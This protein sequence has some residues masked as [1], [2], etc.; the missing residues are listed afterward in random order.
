[1][2]QPRGKKKKKKKREGGET[3]ENKRRRKRRIA[4][5]CKLLKVIYAEMSGGPPGQFYGS[6]KCQVTT[7]S[8]KKTS[9]Y[10]LSMV[11]NGEKKHGH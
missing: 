5:C 2:A 8:Q 7:G 4:T 1:M 11:E 10:L 9:D 6:R 3:K